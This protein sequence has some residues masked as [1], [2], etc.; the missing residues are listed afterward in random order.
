[1]LRPFRKPLVIMTPKSLLRHPLA[2]SGAAEFLGDSHF[3]RLVSDTTEIA[4][5]RVKRLVLCSG[6]VAYDLI[7]KRDEEKLEDVS[8]VRVE[9]LYPFPGEPLSARIAKMD[10]LETIVWCQEE[11]KNNGAW[12]FVDR[13]IEEAAEAAGKQG[14]RPRY[15]GREVAA[16]P[17]TGLASRHKVQQEALVNIALGLA[18][19]GD[20]VRGDTS[21]SRK[22]KA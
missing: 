3:R 17:A 22:K 20:A 5:K 16:S 21:Q 10:N 18:D 8:I 2:K 19:G 1:M 6:K 12:F 9:Q 7:Q 11:P 14:M 4:D 15:A 13:L